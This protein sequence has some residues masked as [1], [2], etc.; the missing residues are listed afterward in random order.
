MMASL[1]IFF[2]VLALLLTSIGLYGV[3]AYMVA[4]RTGE[5][6]IRMALGARSGNVI[7]LVLRE[8][9][10]QVGLGIAAGIVA[11]VFTSKLIGSLLYGITPNDPGNLILAVFTLLAVSALAAY[12]PAS[13]AARI[14]P[15][16][17]LREE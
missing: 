10:G 2:A 7:W 16:L 14:D 6:G 1:S 5:I 15:M 9:A 4:R 11:V 8:I 13:R 3:L 17:A 12:V